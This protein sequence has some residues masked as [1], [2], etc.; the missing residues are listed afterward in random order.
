MEGEQQL[1]AIFLAL[2]LEEK[3]ALL[4]HS[5]NKKRLAPLRD[6]VKQIARMMPDLASYTN[7]RCACK[8]FWKWL[9]PTVSKEVTEMLLMPQIRRFA[10]FLQALPNVTSV[11][12]KTEPTSV[13][14]Q[15]HRDSFPAYVG[16]R[17]ARASGFIRQDSTRIIGSV[18]WS[19]FSDFVNC[20]TA[21]E[22]DY[23]KNWKGFH[24]MADEQI[25]LN[26]KR[27]KLKKL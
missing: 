1:N 19:K 14:I 16:Y 20:E 6:I 15:V 12:L 7:L 26:R 27:K 10:D 17:V 23:R 5:L 25:K 21:R 22:I 18:F 3:R 13:R 11:K 24:P 8:H 9:P 4:V 2:S